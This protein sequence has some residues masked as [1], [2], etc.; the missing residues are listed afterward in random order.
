MHAKTIRAAT[1]CRNL[2]SISLQ[3]ESLPIRRG[4]LTGSPLQQ[5]FFNGFPGSLK[6]SLSTRGGN[7]PEQ[8]SNFVRAQL[9]GHQVPA[10]LEL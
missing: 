9:P 6:A 3:S 7:A 4:D 8:P 1:E 2:S 10:P 5:L